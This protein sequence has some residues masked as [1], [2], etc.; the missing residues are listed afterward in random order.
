ML[1]HSRNSG[2]TV[3][4]TSANPRDP[5]RIV[6]DSFGFG[7][8]DGG[9]AEKDLQAVLEG[10][11]Y[12]ERAY[13]SL[14]L[15]LGGNFTRVWPPPDEVASD[16]EYKRWVRD[17]AWG[18]HASSS[19]GDVVDFLSPIFSRLTVG[20]SGPLTLYIYIPTYPIYSYT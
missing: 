12:A 8:G 4:L 14:L 15:P 2:G 10:V 9:D 18:H 5:P 6:F 16:E 20:A 19:V 17:E 7:G 1:A 3:N 11:R 13:A